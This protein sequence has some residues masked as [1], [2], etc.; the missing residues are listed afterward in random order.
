VRRFRYAPVLQIC[1]PTGE[2]LTLAVAEGFGLR[3]I[4][5][6][7]LPALAPGQGLLIPR[8]AS[9]QTVGMRFPIDVVFVRLARDRVV[10]AVRESIP[11]LRIVRT[12]G[13]SSTAAIELAAGEAR[14]H[15]L[16][17][18]ALLGTVQL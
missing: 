15:G 7:G 16:R 11:P 18:G 8:C 9:V 17:D 2:P 3:L 10:L 4:G 1:P 6:A 5:L 14:R 13:A 12:S